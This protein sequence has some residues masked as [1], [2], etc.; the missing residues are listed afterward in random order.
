VI[1]TGALVDARRAAELAVM[2]SKMSRSK[3]RA[4]V[5]CTNADTARSIG[6]AS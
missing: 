1:A 3:P 5:S 4:A 6:G 2:T